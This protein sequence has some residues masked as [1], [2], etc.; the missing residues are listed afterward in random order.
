MFIAAAILTVPCVQAEQT[1]K[2]VQVSLGYISEMDASQLYYR[3]ITIVPPDGIESVFTLEFIVHGDFQ[4]STAISLGLKNE[5]GQLFFCEPSTWTTAA[6]NAP[7]YTT[8]FDCTSLAK[9]ADF[10]GGSIEVGLIADKVAFNIKPEVRLTYYNNPKYHIKFVHGTQYQSGDDGTVFLQLLDANN[11]PINNSASVCFLTIYYPDKTLFKH[12]QLMQ[13]LEDGIFY[14]DVKVPNT[15]GIYMASAYC[16][17]P[18]TQSESREATEGFESGNFSGGT[19]WNGSWYN[20]GADIV[21]TQAYA[22]NYS[23]KIADDDVLKRNFT[24]TANDSSITV[25]YWYKIDAI[26]SNEFIYVDLIDASGVS[27]QIASYSVGDDDGTWKHKSETLH[28]TTDSYNMTGNTTFRIYTSGTLEGNDIAYFDDIKLECFYPID[29]DLAEFQVIRGSAE[30]NV[31]NANNYIISLEN[32]EMHNFSYDES[33]YFNYI[34]TSYTQT[35]VSNQEIKVELYKNVFPCSEIINITRLNDSTNNYDIVVPYDAYLG[36]RDRCGVVMYQDL[37]AYETFNIRINMKHYWKK[38]LLSQYKK[39]KLENEMLRVG[40]NAY[41]DATGKPVFEVPIT[42]EIP[43][44][45]TLYASCYVFFDTYYEYEKELNESFI[46]LM[47]TDINLTAENILGL[48]EQAVHLFYVGESLISVGNTIA[49]T[50]NNINSYSQSIIADNYPPE[51]PNYSIFFANI[52]SSYINYKEI[53]NISANAAAG[54]TSITNSVNEVKT[55]NDNIRNFLNELVYLITDAFN[56]TVT[57]QTQDT[58]Q[59]VNSAVAVHAEEDSAEQQVNIIYVYIFVFIVCVALG[60]F[61]YNRRKIDE[62]CDNTS[63]IG[64]GASTSNDT[65]SSNINAIGRQNKFR[66]KQ[67]PQYNTDLDR[68]RHSNNYSNLSISNDIRQCRKQLL[69]H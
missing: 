23:V 8:Y 67:E 38:M 3:N 26:D 11:H 16:T 20:D 55:Q 21:D 45:D 56:P 46:P 12:D 49:L 54:L 22:G 9:Q 34:V 29:A 24:A 30:L 13:Y 57:A 19:G 42:D 65:S 48:E 68:F 64:F 58:M 37:N 44:D 39:L 43:D 66:F 60:L 63:N 51:N 32:V 33:V 50:L 27:Y 40:C 7:S 4:Q 6:V 47:D 52:S 69:E 62:K 35:N 1:L 53:N 61:I 2:T 28:E 59:S 15:E 5:Q 31:R 41:Q 36:D 25:S 18:S 17:V 14:Y 10:K